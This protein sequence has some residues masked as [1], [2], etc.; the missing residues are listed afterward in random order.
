VITTT[1]GPDTRLRVLTREQL[2]T[3][4][5]LSQELNSTLDVQSLLPQIL[6]LTL[7]VTESEAGALW[8][9]E[10]EHVRCTH[11]TG[12]AAAALQGVRVSVSE[13]VLGETIASVRSVLVPNALEDERFAAWRPAGSEFRTRSAVTIP[14]VSRGTVLGAVQLV[15]DV[16]GK[17]EFDDRDVA[18][19]EALADDAAA[20]LRKAQL[21][22]SER[23]ARNLK[24]LLEVSHEITSS[25]DT[26]RILLSI[27]NLANRAVP[28]DRCV[29]ALHQGAGLQVRAISAEATVD[30]SAAPI[31]RLEEFLLWAA[32]RG[33]RLFVPDLAD[34]SDVL[35][36][37]IRRSFGEYV[38]E[39]G[40]AG[41]FVVPVADAEGELGLLLFEFARPH[42]LAQWAREAAELLA[43][44]AALALRNAQLYRDVPFISLLEPLAEKR[45]ALMAVPGATLLRWAVAAVAV[46]AVLTLVRLPLRVGAADA[47]VR[48]AVQRPVRAAAGGIVEDI[49][50]R[51][52]E[53]VEAGQIVALLRNE[54]L[55][56]RLEESRGELAVASR[57]AL[58]AEARG[59][60]ATASAE[61]ARAASLAGMVAVLEQE[62][63]AL[64]LA[65]PSA[66]VVLTPRLEERIGEYRSAGEP[67]AWIG[68]PAWAEIELRVRQRDI[69]SVREGHRVRAR[70]S[71][72]PSV[73]F[74]GTVLAISP[75][76]EAEVGEA[77]YAVRA[78][79]DNR[80]GLLR[81]G[82]DARARVLADPVPLGAI[83]FRRPWRW[84]R[85][86]FW[87]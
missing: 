26:D 3:L 36:A 11:A 57:A 9:V 34:E 30:R 1:P 23:R 81:P 7:R 37:Q 18:F 63:A 62:S 53:R 74:E 47:G 12:P 55:S 52:G 41:V 43:M 29:L 80:D 82:M 28:F 25:F 40:V 50:V 66:G 13:G 64:H 48:S 79:F 72:H 22:D 15:N 68:D 67:V 20:A 19:L 58:G 75:L 71:A 44:Q 78:V 61:R 49:R 73:L 84:L 77:L 60:A 31:G 45:R 21:L 39:S 46:L 38:E 83:V 17:D 85:L 5:E 87:W 59:D 70:V 2:E 51:S 86:N 56:A 10:G 32:G 76:A 8:I 14:L 35:A 4:L 33:E 42:A 16:G 6:D 27:V 65:A 24:A 69:G 54:D